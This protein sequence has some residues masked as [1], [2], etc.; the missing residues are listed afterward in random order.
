MRQ[1]ILSRCLVCGVHSVCVSSFPSPHLNPGSC[2]DS[3]SS[4]SCPCV[5]YSL[6]EEMGSHPP[7]PS[8]TIF[9]VTPALPHDIPT[10]LLHFLLHIHRSLGQSLPRRL[11]ERKR[12]DCSRLEN[13]VGAP[14]GSADICWLRVRAQNFAVRVRLCF[15]DG[16]PQIGAKNLGP[17]FCLLEGS[18]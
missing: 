12:H 16:R 11:P 17:V 4:E 6:L 9:S 10:S 1:C 3:H 14:L 13:P 7:S 8:L 15:K 5:K 2:N 18:H